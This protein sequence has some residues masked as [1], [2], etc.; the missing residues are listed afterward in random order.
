MAAY[1]DG[2]KAFWVWY[3]SRMNKVTHER[4]VLPSLKTS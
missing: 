1:H 4:A 2:S 3:I